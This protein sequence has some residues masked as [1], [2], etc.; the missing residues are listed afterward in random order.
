MKNLIFNLPDKINKSDIFISDPFC[1]F[2]INNVLDE[3]IYHY[4]KKEF[5]TEE[6]YFN[7]FN[8]GKKNYLNNESANFFKF[9]NQNK[10]YLNLYKYLNKSE[11]FKIIYNLLK[12]EIIK[13]NERKDLNKVF[14][15][16]FSNKFIIRAFKFFLSFFDI[17]VIK[18]GFEFSIIKD[19]C[20]I[21]L[22]T[23]KMNKLISLMIYFPDDDFDQKDWGT[24]FYK[25]KDNNNNEGLWDS[26]F[27]DENE[28]SKYIDKIEKF[29]Q[30]SFTKNKLVGFLKS[31]NSLH[32]I[33]KIN[34][35]NALRKSIN[36]NYYIQ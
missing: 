30:S 35:K 3:K 1:I 13:I 6:K 24:C 14:L 10:N 26:K 19:D 20:F 5:P 9:I 28:S 12:P 36:I 22:H 7:T 27:M 21:P 2:E 31:N 8:I 16:P 17:K 34:K 32:N 23:D 33:E 11:T 25:F 18:L 4:L 29:Y 15:V